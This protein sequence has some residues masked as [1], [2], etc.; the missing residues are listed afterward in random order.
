MYDNLDSEFQYTDKASFKPQGHDNQNYQVFA[1]N[2]MYH[3]AACSLHA[4]IVPVFSNIPTDPH[5]SRKMKHLS[6]EEAVKHSSMFVDMA[7]SYLSIHPDKS[8]LASITAYVSFV[9]V[10]VQCKALGAQRKLRSKGIGHLYP[11]ISIIE[12]LKEIWRPL[13]G[14][15]CYKLQSQMPIANV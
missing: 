9:C 13:R 15:V 10:M 5:I 14:L 1:I 4:S 8:N 12:R 2:C 6:A 11:A 3:L 7:T